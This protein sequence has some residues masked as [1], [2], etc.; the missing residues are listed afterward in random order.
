MNEE[1]PAAPV[2]PSET[3]AGP[4]KP[5]F[6]RPPSTRK[7]PAK[8]SKP[9][10]LKAFLVL[11]ILI[12]SVVLLGWIGYRVWTILS[13]KP[14]E[15]SRNVAREWS[16]TYAK[17]K[18][19]YRD[20]LKLESKVWMTGEELKPEDLEKI[21]AGLKDYESVAEKYHDLREAVLKQGKPSQE[22]LD[23]ERRMI[24]VKAWIWDANGVLEPVMKPLEYGGLYVPMYKAEKR[25]S[26]AAKRLKEIKEKGQEIR[27]SG[28]AAQI[29]KT[30]EEIKALAERFAA[31]RDEFGRLD[32]DLKKGLTLPDLT[33]EGLRELG[34]L[35]EYA[36]TAQ[37]CF[38]ES[39]EL[40]SEFPTE[41]QP[42]KQEPSKEEPPKEPPKETP[43]E[44]P[45]EQPPKEDPPKKDPPK[46]EPPKEPP[47]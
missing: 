46:E 9:S 23:M 37:M 11:G 35:R 2:E 30:V 26:E 20:I 39:R 34:E 1:T 22:L 29:K 4:A 43:K 14:A 13:R 12:S 21:K 8:I 6:P 40:R 28:D 47:K 31:C 16:D 44:T 36:S 15:P 24:E 3:P 41:E 38:K 25:M 33:P 7:P 27:A 17:A 19:A 18:D 32:D 10:R 45:K 42:P 5:A